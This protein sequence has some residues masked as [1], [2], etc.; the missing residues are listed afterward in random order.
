MPTKKYKRSEVA[1]K[2]IAGMQKVHERLIAEKKKNNNEL[3]VLRDNKIVRIK[4]E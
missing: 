4:P 2:I 3:V 1:E